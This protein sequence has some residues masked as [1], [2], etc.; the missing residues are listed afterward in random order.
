MGKIQRGVKAAMLRGN[1]PATDWPYALRHTVTFRLILAMIARY[2]L[3]MVRTDVKNLC[4]RF[5]DVLKDCGMEENPWLPKTFFKW[6]N[7]G[8]CVIMGQHFDDA[9]FGGTSLAVISEMLGQIQKKFGLMVNYAPKKISGCTVDRERDRERNLLKIHQGEYIRAKLKKL[10][11]N[12][13]KPETNP[14]R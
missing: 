6:K 10:G 3:E 12:G 8:E 7:N 5:V 14:G 9:I 13:E 1:A 2:D 11:K 4:V